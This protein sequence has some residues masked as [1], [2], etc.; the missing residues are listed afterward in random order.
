KR[1]VLDDR[2]A[3]ADAI[4]IAVVVV[5]WIAIQVVEPAIGVKCGVVVRPVD[6]S[7]ESIG[8]RPRHHLKLSCPARKLG[9][10]RRD[11][12]ADFL[13][14]IRTRERYRKSASFKPALRNDDAIP[15]RIR[16]IDSGTRKIPFQSPYSCSAWSRGYKVDDVSENHRQLAQLVFGK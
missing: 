14:Q 6:T 7:A 10:R 9:I 1:P 16:R 15:S 8:S 2:P 11:D 3:N 5:F 13:H 4:F 12:D